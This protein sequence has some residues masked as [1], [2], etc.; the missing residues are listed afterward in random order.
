VV[1][2]FGARILPAAC[3]V[4]LLAGPA[5]A[6]R[7]LTSISRDLEHGVRDILRVWASPI[8]ADRNEWATFAA[9][10]ALVGATLF[11]DDDV[12]SAMVR[13]PN[14]VVMWGLEPFRE[15][16]KAEL[17]NLGSGKRLQPLSALLYAF[18]FAFD[19]RALR[20]AGMGCASTQQANILVHHGAYA[21]ISRERPL[22]ANG[23]PYLFELGPGPWREHSFY[24]GHA[25]N[26]MGCVTY[27]NERF[28]L[29][30]AEPVL[31]L[32]AI[33]V[34]L[35]R[36]ADR[37]HWLSDTVTGMLVGHAFGRVIARRARAR[38]AAPSGQPRAQDPGQTLLYSS[39]SSGNATLVV[40][41][42]MTF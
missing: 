28:D 10:A 35:G 8:H 41:W 42:R 9:S 18:G 25:G 11:I 32:L 23:D 24:G 21:L 30:P 40:G 7:T 22:T 4:V 1:R 36:V 5:N 26:I 6:Q 29:G 17:V 20:D 19:S 33:G 13:H 12:D 34:G 39:H 2:G 38:A 37:R 3:G 14:S 16:H 15:E 31:Y 27:W